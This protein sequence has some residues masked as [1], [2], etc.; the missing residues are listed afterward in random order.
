MDTHPYHHYLFFNVANEFYQLP[1]QEQKEIKA[2][3]EKFLSG[4]DGLIITGYATLGFNAKTTFMLWCRGKSPIA[5]Q[6]ML[7]EL[8]RTKLD[9]YL[10][11]QYS[12]FGI[13]R[14][15]EYSG[16]AGKPEQVMQNYKDRLP[17]F[18]LY[19][20]TKTHEWHALDAEN[21]RSIMGE[22]IK[23][24]IGHPNIRQCL[25]YS[26]GIDDYE[27]IVSYEMN[28]LEEFQDLVIEMRRTTGRKYTFVDTPTFTCIYK[29]LPE[30]MEWL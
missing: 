11:I 20:F 24:G 8:L 15:S 29:T 25:L 27:F 19:P 23:V 21:R 22:H 18:V 12:Y 26:Y 6:D 28:T 2:E 3:F 4:A 16:R 10:T 1:A 17:Y 13:V 30:L 7:R 5:V 14:N 9:K